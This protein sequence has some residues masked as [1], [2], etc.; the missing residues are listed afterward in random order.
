MHRQTLLILEHVQRNLPLT[1]QSD[2]NM[3]REIYQ[4]D[5]YYRPIV[6]QHEM[7]I[8]ANCDVSYNSIG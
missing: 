5:Q 1:Y 8:K 7:K 6:G 3:F 2:C 4:T